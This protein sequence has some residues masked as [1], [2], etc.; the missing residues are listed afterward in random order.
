MS[1]FF[2]WGLTT[3][4]GNT[5]PSQDIGSGLNEVSFEALLENLA[6]GT[7]HFRASALS[8]GSTLRGADQI[9]TIVGPA[10]VTS[11]AVVTGRSAQLRGVANPRGVPMSVRFDWG[12]TTE[13]GNQTALLDIGSGSTDVSF[14]ADIADLTPGTYHFRAVGVT[15]SSTVFG[16]DQSFVIAGPAVSVT[17]VTVTG[18]TAQLR[19]TANPQGFASAVRFE[20]GA[21]TAY[22]NLT[23]SQDIGSGVAPVNFLE[24]LND[25]SPGTYHVRAL[26]TYSGTTVPGENATFTIT[27][28]SVQ[29]VSALPAGDTAELR[30]TVTPQGFPIA[31]YFE[32]G[33]T[34]FSNTTERQ[35]FS[36]LQASQPYSFTIR[37]LPVGS[38]QFRAVIDF[39]GQI[40]RGE[41]MTFTILGT[42]GR[43]ARLSGSSYIRTTTW[44]NDMFDDEDFTIELWFKAE[45]PGVLINEADTSDVT[46]WDY[47]F[48]ELL[49]GGIIKAGAPGVPSFTVGTIP[50]NTWHHISVV[51][52]GTAKVMYA[53][54]DGQ[55]A[56]SSAGDRETPR[57]VSRTSVYCIGRGGMFNLGPGNFLSGFIDNA[58]F[59]RRPLS[60][61]EISQL[62]NKVIPGMDIGLMANWHF[63]V[64]GTGAQA[65][66]SPDASGNN[67]H[68]WY[69]PD[70]VAMPIEASGAPL[71]TDQRPAA[72]GATALS[73]SPGIVSLRGSVSPRGLPVQYFFEY[74]RN[75]AFQQTAPVSLP[76]GE[77][78]VAVEATIPVLA[79]VQY[80]FRLV[81]SNAQGSAATPLASLASRSWP[82]NALRFTDGDY[83]RT[84][85]QV[86]AATF[87]TKSTTIEVWFKPTAAGVIAGENNGTS[88]SGERSLIEILASGSVEARFTGLTPISLGSATLNEWNHVAIRYDEP[89]QTMHGFL[90]G[91]KSS[92]RVGTRSPIPNQ[93]YTFGRVT[94]NNRIGTGESFK[95]DMDEI[96][97]WNVARSDDDIVSWKNLII[98]Q[99]ADL[100]FYWRLDSIS[101]TAIPDNGPRGIAGVASSTQVVPSTAPLS[102]GLRIAQNLVETQFFGVPNSPALLQSTSNFTDWTTE[103]ELTVP[104]SGVVR[105]PITIAPGTKLFRLIP[106]PPQ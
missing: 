43:A 103:A 9:F 61:L 19:A 94:A 21:T 45:S 95:G 47:A 1:V 49:P 68:A 52:D 46:R 79:D 80:E 86:P 82:G 85:T 91:V 32:W 73:Y 40:T 72:S 23:P 100:V 17:S 22:G 57:E 31:A 104:A 42:A 14:T 37:N 10:A 2:E 34:D 84:A 5:T 87:P 59:W 50:F 39:G 12:P 56:G 96:R 13:Y 76:A 101:G 58:R 51:Y 11:P 18:R 55:P 63:D 99:E 27:A 20:W 35:N 3:T 38:Y 44:S 66:T 62:Y 78:P 88:A 67:N 69:V 106:R 24:N 97:V 64:I 75:G 92:S 98:G 77:I 70:N 83:I 26:I 30:G 33:T 15:P 71:A 89:T 60:A 90:N 102:F 41:T 81:A 16:A 93:N 54:L 65:F 28:P 7:Y 105:T 36:G 8:G 74:G 25:L 6:P 53:Y 4:Y 29:T 48:A